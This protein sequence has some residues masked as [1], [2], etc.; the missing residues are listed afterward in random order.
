[1]TSTTVAPADASF[2]VRAWRAPLGA[3]AAALALVLLALLPWLGTSR[4]FSADEGA[5]VAQAHVLADGKGWFIDHPRP[6]LDPDGRFFLLHLSTSNGEG[7]A[8]FAKHPVY[9]GALAPL[10][11]VGGKPAMV[12]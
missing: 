6:D 4:L 8:P 11:A 2:A 7:S 5:L 1:M 12:L 3:H 9:A 10:E